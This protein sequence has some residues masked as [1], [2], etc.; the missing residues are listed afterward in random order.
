V[1]YKLSLSLFTKTLSLFIAISVLC[2][3]VGFPANHRVSAAISFTKSG[4]EVTLQNELYVADAWVIKNASDDYEMWYTHARTDLGLSDIADGFNIFLTTGIIDAITNLDL[5]ALINE[6][7]AI[8]AAELYNY[9][10]ASSTIIGYATSTDGQTW[11]VQESEALLS[12]SDGAW[13]SVGTPCVIK[14]APGDYEMWY[15][16]AETDLT[17]AQLQVY[18][19]A[20]SSTQE[21]IKNAILALMDE[22]RSVIAYATSSDGINWTEDNNSVLSTSSNGIWS[23][24]L[25]PCVVKDG[26]TYKMWYTSA[27]T[28]L[29]ETDLDNLLTNIGSLSI[30][31]L[32]GLVGGTRSVI[33]YATSSDGEVW[34]IGNDEVISDGGTDILSSVG[35]PSVVMNGSTYEMWY[36]RLET[37]LSTDDISTVLSE[38]PSLGLTALLDTLSSGDYD[39]FLIALDNLFTTNSSMDNI[40][41]L[42]TG[43]TSTIG[44][45]SSANG[46]SWAVDSQS[47]LRGVADTPWS[48]IAAPCVLFD[49]GLYEMWYTEGIEELSAQSLSDVLLGDDLL[50]GYATGSSIS[51]HIELVTGWNLIGLPV[52]PASPD[53]GDVLA[54]IIDDV[55]IVWHYNATTFT[56][57]FFTTIAGAENSLTEMTEG[58]GYWIEMTSP[59]T[60]VLSTT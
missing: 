43:T 40:K 51:P 33:G 21:D 34:T 5:A 23:S 32:W 57:T 16:R 60:L 22:G 59:N 25:D 26:A 35:S 54:D 4:E 10:N 41:T 12:N 19:D 58:S 31:D 47:T 20:L 18:I 42:L 14:N 37:N 1:D 27:K 55:N 2:T 50:I 53:I 28:D 56:W 11:T 9:L 17:I 24:A 7:A 3:L 44:Y 52:I 45:A 8:D 49:N 30:D 38:I 46:T 6:L 29:D 48:G 36:T 15:T 39:A 13:N